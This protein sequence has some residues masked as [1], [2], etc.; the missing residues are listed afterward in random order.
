[1]AEKQTLIQNL[2]SVKHE[3]IQVTIEDDLKTVH[4]YL[5]DGS[6]KL[7]NRIGLLNYYYKKHGESQCM[8]IVNRISTM[9]QFSG[10]KILEKYLY[11]ICTN[12]EISTFL[13]IICAKS[14]CYFNPENKL[15]YKA[16]DFICKGIG[17]RKKETQDADTPDMATPCRIDAVCLLMTNKTYKKKANGYFCSII[18]DMKL[19]CDY[20]Y[21]TILS[22]E[23]KDTPFKDYFLKEACLVFFNNYCNMTQYR[24]LAGQYLIQNCKIKGNT[25][26]NVEHSLLELAQDTELD[27]N[28]RADSADVILRLG[29]KSN[30]KIA[31]EIIMV[32]G[33]QHG[34]VNN[35]FDNAQNVHVNEIEDSVLKGLEFL[36]SIETKTVSGV[37]GAPT[38]TFA[39]VKKQIADMLEK[40]ACNKKKLEKKKHDEKVDKI[41]ISLNRIYLDRALYGKYNCTLLHILLKIWTYIVS[42]DAEMDM[43]KRLLEELIDMS[44]TC[45][46][47]FA[48]RLVNVISGF[49]DFNI[50]ISWRD[51][52]IANF[53]GRLNA[54]ARDITNKT[55]IRQHLDL[56]EKKICEDEKLKGNKT[57]SQQMSEVLEEFQAK[58]LEEMVIR[59]DQFSSRNNFLT[60]FRKN[61]LGIRQ[62]L[63]EEFKQYITDTDFDLY[64]RA[65]ISTYETGEYV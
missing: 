57:P 32:L 10:T 39:Y 35:I 40:E 37:P 18:N 2:K 28:L 64:F 63:Y 21:K 47:G 7:K 13:K 31:T 14:L 62:E 61:M 23:Q 5:M 59:S 12:C 24:V 41:H 19:E 36:V 51:Q 3:V 30:K 65:A 54:S 26:K 34:H 42:H 17:A 56:Y 4:D 1:M 8:E 33:R 44:G 15:G 16:L 25:L 22:L 52:I 20:R 43:K 27:Y 38:I 9:Y 55:K 49:G 29:T 53:T 6:V 58:V 50:T 48:T 11:E 45:S 60:F 46:T